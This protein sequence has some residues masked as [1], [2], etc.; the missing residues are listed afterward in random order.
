MSRPYLIY[1]ILEISLD[2]VPVHMILIVTPATS[3]HFFSTGRKIT[4]RWLMF[5]S[6]PDAGVVI[7]I[8]LKIS[9]QQTLKL[10]NRMA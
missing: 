7:E 10:S 9:S 5:R 3:A 8:K 1:R 4:A 6:M 2:A